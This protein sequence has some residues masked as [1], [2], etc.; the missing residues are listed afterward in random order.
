MLAGDAVH[1]MPPF[2]G[3]GL[4][5]GFWDAG[6]LAWRL[7]L[8]LSGMADPDKLLMAYQIERLDHV[9]KLTVSDQLSK[10]I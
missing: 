1:L 10:R 7:P 6:A 3:Q 5:S 2:I 4:S 8:I 9:R